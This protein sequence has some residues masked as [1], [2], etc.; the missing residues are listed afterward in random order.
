MTEKEREA[1]FYPQQT[2]SPPQYQTNVGRTVGVTSP[3]VPGTYGSSQVGNGMYP[4]A[5]ATATATTTSPPVNPVQIPYLEPHKKSL[6]EA[7]LLCIPLGFLG[8]HH[9]YLGRPGFGVLYF[10]T[11]GLMGCGWVVDMFRLPCLVQ[12]VNRRNKEKAVQLAET[13]MQRLQQGLSGA[14]YPCAERD[15]RTLADAYV[16]WFPLGILGAHHFYLRNYGFGVLYLFTFGLLGFGWLIDLFRMP[17]LVKMANDKTAQREYHSCTAHI[18]AVSPA[19]LLGAH[20]FY[21]N[22]PLW[23]L[24]YLCTFGIGGI[25][26]IA[27]W[28]R[29]PALARRAN[30]AAR[31][32]TDPETAYMDDAYLLWCPPLGLL[33]FHQYY[34]RRPCWGVVYS[35]TFGLFGI[36]WLVDLFRLP[37]MVRDYNARKDDVRRKLVDRLSSPGGAVAVFHGIGGNE[38]VTTF[39][40]QCGYQAGSP[41]MVTVSH[42]TPSAQQAGGPAPLAPIP[43]GPVVYGHPGYQNGA[44][45]SAFAY[46]GPYP[47]YYTQPSGLQPPG[48]ESFGIVHPPAY[49]PEVTSSPGQPAISPPSY[50][51]SVKK[52]LP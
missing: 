48:A 14:V 5:A 23:G 40:G 25:G 11:F 4:S 36:G 34:L 16:L 1:T 38:R 31:G 22:R 32:E 41:V 52:D 37:F 2:A 35:L 45:G 30:Q 10:L 47:S 12:Q 49:T 42:S 46:P 28:F 26:W 43:Q 39:Y 9:F 27:D 33:G 51:V 21:L 29:V 7:Y 8:A 15:P 20:H 18:L 44:Y 17:H 6:L 50:E 24:L 3:A 13:R 19:G